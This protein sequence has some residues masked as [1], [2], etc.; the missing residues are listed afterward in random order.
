MAWRRKTEWV[1]QLNWLTGIWTSGLKSETGRDVRIKILWWDFCQSSKSMAKFLRRL[2]QCLTT[3]PRLVKW[4]GQVSSDTAIRPQ[5]VRRIGGRR[6]S[7]EPWYRL[8]PTEEFKSG[9]VFETS[10]DCFVSS[11]RP[12]YVLLGINMTEKTGLD[13]FKEAPKDEHRTIF[14]NKTIEGLK[15]TTNRAQ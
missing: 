12:A 2:H 10:N 9:M 5:V 15:G 13:K 7:M 8:N 4:I 6:S 3:F 14:R 1:L 11:V